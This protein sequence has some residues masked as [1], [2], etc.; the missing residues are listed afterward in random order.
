MRRFKYDHDVIVDSDTG[1]RLSTL[2]QCLDKLNDLNALIDMELNTPDQT[3]DLDNS[4][5][6]LSYP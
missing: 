4:E 1:E 6:F 5:T 2:E 3:T